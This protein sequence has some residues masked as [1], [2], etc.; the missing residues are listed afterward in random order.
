MFDLFKSHRRAALRKEALTEEQR[1]LVRRNVRY[2][3]RLSDGDRKE[4]E[5]LVRVFL[6]DKAFEGCAGL[7]VT[8]LRRRHPKLYGELAAFTNRIPRAPEH[9]GH[10]G[11]HLGAVDGDVAR[12]MT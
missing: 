11:G 9:G 2:L 1:A 7:E 8:A 6:A 3:S 5:G 12:G 4:L 10:L